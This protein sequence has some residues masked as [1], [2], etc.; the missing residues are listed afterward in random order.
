MNNF[1]GQSMFI[2]HLCVCLYNFCFANVIDV[3][4][5]ALIYFIVCVFILDR[6]NYLTEM[7]LLNPL[8]PLILI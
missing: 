8:R 2:F 1:D 7:I 3:V 4:L 5:Y 6:Y